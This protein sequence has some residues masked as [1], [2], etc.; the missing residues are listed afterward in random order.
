LLR[1][2]GAPIHNNIGRQLQVMGMI[3]IG[4]CGDPKESI[5][6]RKNES[7]INISGRIIVT[8]ANAA[9]QSGKTTLIGGQVGIRPM[10]RAGFLHLSS[11]NP[12]SA[13]VINQS[14]P[15]HITRY[16]PACGRNVSAFSDSEPVVQTAVGWNV[17]RIVHVIAIG[18]GCQMNPGRI[19]GRIGYC[20]TVLDEKIRFI[21]V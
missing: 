21:I 8:V 3:G 4:L 9:W 6:P 19:V 11:G 17:S 5:V 10:R 12:L 15:F 13:Q 20:I 14:G 2:A 18:A 1:K 7:T 16:V